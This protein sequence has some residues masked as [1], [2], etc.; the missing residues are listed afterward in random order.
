M[1]LLLQ[2]MEKQISGLKPKGL[3]IY[4]SFL[5]LTWKLIYISAVFLTGYHFPLCVVMKHGNREIED[6]I[7][8]YIIHLLTI[9]LQIFRCTARQS[10]L[11]KMFS[12]C[13]TSSRYV[14]KLT[15]F[16]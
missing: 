3:T 11:F 5:I 15:E 8:T 14:Q 7:G 13:S 12:Y 2:A 4:L 1:K 9:T 6:T 16:W 10:E